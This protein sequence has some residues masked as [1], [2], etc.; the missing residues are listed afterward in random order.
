MSMS[1]KE[2]VT[3]DLL[4]H[5]VHGLCRVDEIAK[6]NHSGRDVLCYSL[7]P[8]TANRM[9]VRFVVSVVD[10]QASG[11]H[12][13]VSLKEAREILGYLRAGVLAAA[14][15]EDQAWVFAKAIL[16]S[17]RDNLEFKDARKRQML[18]RSAKG[19]VGELA[20]VLKTTLKEMAASVQ[21]SL[22]NTSQISPMVLTALAHAGQD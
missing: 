7:V 22:G 13:P 4:Y 9:K 12:A 17:S 10:I 16:S 6:E 14:T 3:G 5:T 21:K 8:N 1:Q 20:F 11:F 19:L 18:E 2:M 15:A